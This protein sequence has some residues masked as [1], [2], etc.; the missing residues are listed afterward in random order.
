MRILGIMNEE[1][2]LDKDDFSNARYNCVALMKSPANTTA[3]LMQSRC[4]IP[5]RWCVSYGGNKIPECR[6]L[7]FT[8]SEVY[9]NQGL[10]RRNHPRVCG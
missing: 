9:G 2:R 4:G 1:I 5:E 3:A 10:G 7:P 6:P 8:G